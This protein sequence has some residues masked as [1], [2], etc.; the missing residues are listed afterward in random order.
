MNNSKWRAVLLLLLGVMLCAMGPNRSVAKP[1]DE[2]RPRGG[3]VGWARIITPYSTWAVHDVED[4]KLA[5]FI[6]TQTSLNIESTWYS[7][8]PSDLNQLC[9]YPFLYI[10]NLMQIHKESELKNIGEYLQRGGF[11]FV[12]T[13]GVTQVART[14]AGYVKGNETLFKKLVP[15]SEVRHLPENHPI[16]HCFFDVADKDMF[17]P[18]MGV[19]VHEEYEG[20][21][22]VF[23]GDRMI[24]LISMG[25]EC[26]WWV[27]DAQREPGCKKMMTN[28]YIYAITRATETA[29]EKGP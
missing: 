25:L 21:Y 5:K 14:T 23:S 7:A 1:E 15:G 8:D 6:Q 17:T 12:D 27:K 4:G 10:K 18:D 24:G 20:L 16:Y 19:R 3:R 22:G 28:I 9:T 11:L 13:C 29:P 26:G 2:P